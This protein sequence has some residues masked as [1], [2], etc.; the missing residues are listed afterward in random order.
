MFKHK[1]LIRKILLIQP[2]AFCDNRRENMNPN[3][4]LGIAYIA[5]VL[6][7][8]GYE[9]K[10]LDAF[11]EGWHIEERITKEKL[12]LGLPFDEIKKIIK[13]ELPDA[14]GITSMFTAQRANA[15]ELAKIV[16]DFDSKITVIMGGAHPTA[17]PESVLIDNNVDVAVLGEGDATIIPLLQL[18]EKNASLSELEGIGYRDIDGKIILQ[19]TGK[20]VEDLDDIPFPARHLLPMEK[21]FSSG[22]RHGGIGKGKRSAS[23]ITS[24]GCQYLCNFCTAFKVFGR[25][26]RK[27]SK[28]NVLAEIYELV[29]NNNVDEI[30]FEDDQL[31]AKR[32]RAIS[33]FEGLE[34]Y[35]L[36][37]D[38][39]NGIS[40]W[41]L[42]ED[43]ILRMKK[44]GCY[45]INLAIES[46][47]QEVLDHIINKPV[48][49]NQIPDLV[50]IIRKHGME[51]TLF[52][53]VGNISEDRV[54][55]VEEIQR[56]F[57]FA[58]K[59]K[60]YPHASL[61]TAYPGS[62][63]LTI[64]EE[65]GYL[66]PGFNWDDLLIHTSQLQT[67]EW[68]PE[69]LVDLV[70]KERIKTRWW[71]FLTSPLYSIIFTWHHFA[72]HPIAT[73]E[74]AVNFLRLSANSA[75]R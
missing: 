70:H 48:K 13:D 54:E 32:D 29:N 59:L 2:P 44:S 34:K 20:Q 35:N 5:A 30:Y 52:L 16:K 63:V 66:V 57:K 73:M 23:I 37:W 19:G 27:R 36:H 50:R 7:K 40:S 24:R 43:I 51:P 3:A 56:S 10:I 74:K 28:E 68:S 17:A 75:I 71:I 49:V 21:Y 64:A 72:K 55:T 12:R 31:L 47:V 1:K 46:G 4:P 8:G 15:H 14:V 65:K 33:L 11:I 45:R 60:I 53:V 6:E 18:I 58:R 22:V 26:P 62:D 67:K 69:Q 39:P 9:V 41:L 38:T 42:N 61:L 25:R